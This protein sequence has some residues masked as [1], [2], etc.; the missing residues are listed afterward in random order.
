[1]P[2]LSYNIA[3]L[4]RNILRGPIFYVSRSKFSGQGTQGQTNVV[5]LISEP[6]S[7]VSRYT[8]AIVENITINIDDQAN[9]ATVTFPCDVHDAVSGNLVGDEIKIRLAA[10]EGFLSQVIFRGL[11][12]QPNFD[13]NPGADGITYECIGYRYLLNSDVIWG[14]QKKDGTE[15]NRNDFIATIFNEDD[16]PD[17]SV[18]KFSVNGFQTNVFDK[19]GEDATFWTVGD[20]LNYIF[21]VEAKSKV[22]TA[23]NVPA[24]SDLGVLDF[25]PKH[26]ELQNEQIATAI[27]RTMQQMGPAYHWWLDDFF[28][29]QGGAQSNFRWFVMGGIDNTSA[30]ARIDSF[31]TL[32]GNRIPS[33][34]DTRR[35]FTIG[36]I[37]ECVEDNPD[38]NV[39]SMNIQEDGS[40]LVN[41]I[42]VQGDF[43]R[44]ETVFE[45]SKDWSVS[46]ESEF[47][48][49]LPNDYP[50]ISGDTADPEDVTKLK[51]ALA[52]AQFENVFRWFKL[53][54][55]T[56][57]DILDDIEEQLDDKFGEP[58]DINGNEISWFDRDN[59]PPFDRDLFTQQEDLNGK[60]KNIRMQ[61]YG[62][63]DARRKD[64]ND[65]TTRLV[66]EAFGSWTLGTHRGS[67]VIDPEQPRVKFKRL[68]ADDTL[69]APGVVY[70]TVSIPTQVRIFT[71]TGRKGNAQVTVTRM[72]EDERFKK[73]LRHRSLVPERQ[74][75]NQK[76][77]SLKVPDKSARP[78]SIV[79]YSEDD[80]S[81]V[82]QDKESGYVLADL[83]DGDPTI[84]RDDTD[85]MVD[86]ADDYV[87]ALQRTGIAAN[88]RLP[89]ASAGY[90]PGQLI[91]RV[92]N[93]GFKRFQ[94]S[95]I[96]GVSINGRDFSTEINTSNK[97][98]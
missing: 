24:P 86:F 21:V 50:G 81:S 96:I 93:S 39:G 17:K 78:I 74:V 63:V 97:K 62:F 13:I 11:V 92:N 64:A 15:T 28:S 57:K 60:K 82:A 20:I 85:E 75:E 56:I 95:T 19:G 89:F 41:R 55:T 16:R 27:T 94:D 87:D 72:I 52:D 34:R 37:G 84:A 23:V 79:D 7:L 71:D 70:V 18:D 38:Y 76:P 51:T 90:Q 33:S 6:R 48:S 59:M 91:K 66:D 46:E 49:L 4:T 88:I 2:T 43:V 83:P 69:D 42:I 44:V 45:L 54:S 26:F 22:P 80:A 9:V 8:R 77:T 36:K 40:E 1:M 10:F 5:P 67:Y 14:I 73:V 12:L 65:T 47:D 32:S 31:N 30:G 58:T 53:D 98:T 61:V 68:I 3:E 25:I 29:V 35:I